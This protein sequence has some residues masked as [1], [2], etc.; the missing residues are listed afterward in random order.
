[1]HAVCNK[2]VSVTFRV[3]Q[4]QYAHTAVSYGAMGFVQSITK[5]VQMG[6]SIYCCAGKLH[7]AVVLQSKL[8]QI[9]TAGGANWHHG[10]LEALELLILVGEGS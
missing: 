8:G 9:W 1:M 4:L 7:V 6:G 3:S 2:Y 5:H 10:K